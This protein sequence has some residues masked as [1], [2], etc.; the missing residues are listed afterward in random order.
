MRYSESKKD[1][2]RKL[3]KSHG[4]RSRSAFKLI[5]INKSFRLIKPGYKILDIG[6]SPGGWLQ[7]AAEITEK[8]GQIIGIDLKHTDPIEG[9][10]IM[11]GDIREP[12]TVREVENKFGA[13]IDVILSDL[14]P[15]VSGL[16]ELDHARQIDLT[17]ISLSL[18]KNMLRE[19]GGALFK[20]FQGDQLQELLKEMKFNFKE[21]IISKPK[22]SR[23]ESSEIY[24]VAKDFKNHNSLS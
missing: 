21:A 1:Q 8:R 11:L 7:V 20:V 15:N 3:A 5:Q 13:K 16:W 4:Y 14:A 23:D 12:E 2:Y 19:G 17:K 24:I 10:I 6:C 9:V 22:A 18:A